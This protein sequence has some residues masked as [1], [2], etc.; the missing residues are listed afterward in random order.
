MTKDLNVKDDLPVAGPLLHCVG[1]L[2]DMFLR[3]ANKMRDG[4]KACAIESSQ[5]IL[6][7]R[8]A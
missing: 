8:P 6:H 5:P 1:L 4:I 2:L 3:I 7:N